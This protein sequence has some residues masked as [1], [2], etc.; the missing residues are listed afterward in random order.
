[1]LQ[2]YNF[3]AN[4]NKKYNMAQISDCCGRKYSSTGDKNYY[5]VPNLEC[6]GYYFWAEKKYKEYVIVYFKGELDMIQT[7]LF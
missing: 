1:M 7:F 5:C 4:K 6:K 3:T 2:K